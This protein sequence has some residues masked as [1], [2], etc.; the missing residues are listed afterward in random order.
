[1]IGLASK[2]EQPADVQRLTSY[3]MVCHLDVR[4]LV[5]LSHL[6]WSARFVK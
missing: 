6:S 4:A 3:A 2:F 1:M 5:W